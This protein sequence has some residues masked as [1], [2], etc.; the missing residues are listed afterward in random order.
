MVHGMTTARPKV[1][2][3][4]G[5]GRSGTTILA[6]ILGEVEG[7]VNTGELRWIWARGVVEQRL[8]GCGR[9]LA[10]CPVLSQVLTRVLDTAAIGPDGRPPAAVLDILP[11]QRELTLVRDRLQVIRSASGGGGSWRA[12]ERMRDVT[13]QL[14]GSIGDVTGAHVFIDTSKRAQDAAVLATLDQIDHYVLHIVR[15]PRVVAWSWQRIKANPVV[16]GSAAMSTRAP[17]PSVAWWNENCLAPNCFAT[18]SR[19]GRWM[20]L[21]YED[22]AARPRGTVDRISSPSSGM[23][24]SPRSSAPTRWSCGPTTPSRATRT[25]SGP[26]RYRSGRTRNGAAE[27]LGAIS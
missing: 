24:W 4:V 25:G 23:T 12:L 1:L 21:C 7:A 6:R 26:A 2:S 13:I 3:I 9:P 19:R 14:L 27:C 22:F 17:V 10:D 8:C 11:A 15:D 5:P 18:T 20:S 16:V